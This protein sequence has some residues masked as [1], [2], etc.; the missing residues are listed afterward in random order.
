MRELSIFADEAG[1]QDM[2]EGYYLLTL[3]M[4]DQSEHIDNHTAEYE[5]QLPVGGLRDVPFHMV[6]LLHGHRDY[7]GLDTITRKRLLSRFN[8]F[9]RRLPISYHTFSYSAYDVSGMWELSARMR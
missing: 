7:E 4:H 8:A 2:S 1:L 9:V 3:V 6:D 5:R